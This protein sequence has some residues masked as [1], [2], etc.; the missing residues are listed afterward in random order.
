MEL[1]R[2]RCVWPPLWSPVTPLRVSHPNAPLALNCFISFLSLFPLPPATRSHA[3]LL[4]LLLT[5]K[6]EMHFSQA[7]RQPRHATPPLPLLV[8]LLMY[9]AIGCI[10]AAP[11]LQHRRGYDEMMGRSGPLPTVTVA[12][13]ASTT[14]LIFGIF[15]TIVQP[16]LRWWPGLHEMVC[17]GGE[18]R[19]VEKRLF[20]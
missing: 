1:V 6:Q 13:R 14:T 16:Q 10:A 17:A 11:A 19:L 5:R 18:R 12:P 7:M 20:F 3:A 2:M 8:L 15:V 9:C 4:L